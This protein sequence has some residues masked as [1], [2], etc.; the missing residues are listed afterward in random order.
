MNVLIIG[1]GGREHAIAWKLNQSSQ[2]EKLFIAPGN[3][4]TEEEGTNVDLDIT[5]FDE[6]GSFCI[7]NK[8]G[9]V[10][11]GPEAPLVN[12][13][14]DFFEANEKLKSI[15][16]IGPKKAGAQLESSKSF[17][18][19]FMKRHNIPTAKYLAVTKDNLDAGTDFLGKL[20]G[21]YVLKAD[22][23]AAGKGVLI[24]EDLEEA[25][26]EL[27]AML[28]GKFGSAS[29]T[30]VIEEF[31]DGKEVSV[32]VITDGTSYKIL[33]SAKDYKRIGEG[34]K[35]LNTGG[36]GA[37]S[38]VTFANKDFLDKV[39]NQV[40]IPTIKGLKKEGIDY[41]G[42]IFF[43]IINVKKDPYVIEYNCRL[44]DPE[45]EVVMLRLKSDLLELFDGLASGTLSERNVEIDPR[46]ATTVMMVSKGYPEAYEKGKTI[47]GLESVKDSFVFHSGTTKDSANNIVTNGGRVLT[48]SSFGKDV[49]TALTKSYASVEKIDFEGKNY[50]KDIGLDLVKKD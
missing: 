22:G 1:S 43:G 26:S 9:V 17:S 29:K 5:N 2:L 13:I 45:T 14:H 25:K 24:I 19:A 38:P 21:P 44:G 16:V 31:L 33:P 12:G 34:E 6:V 4:G 40:I 8:V 41:S 36:M 30:V 28:K 15:C 39:D 18:K 47:T 37:V 23:L 48:V 50:R 20:K 35:G 42:F 10:V 32:F 49:P 11:V 3:A 7:E 46:T 27:K